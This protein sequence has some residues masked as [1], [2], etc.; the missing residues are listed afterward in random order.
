MKHL[1]KKILSELYGFIYNYSPT[2]KYI[3]FQGIKFIVGSK[4]L[5]DAFIKY[6]HDKSK[7]SN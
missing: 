6:K 4:E 3:H 7:N 1:N 5:K 2:P